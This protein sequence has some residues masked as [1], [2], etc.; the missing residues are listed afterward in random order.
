MAKRKKKQGGPTKKQI[1]L[2]KK[3]QRFRRRLMIGIGAV[4]A[5]IV[6][7][8]IF[9]FYRIYIAEPVSPVAVVNGTS[10]R[11]DYY[12]KMVRYQRYI[13]RSEIAQLRNRQA[14]LNPEDENTS[15]LSDYL[16][17]SIQQAESRL[18]TVGIDVLDELINDELIRQEATKRGI[19]LS[20]QEINEGIEK[21]FGFI[22]NQ[23]TPT[24]V[25]ATLTITPTP[26]IAPMTEEQ[27]KGYYQSYLDTIAKVA[28][29]SEED[30]RH[31]VEN[32][33]L[34]RKLKEALAEEVPTAAEQVH[35]RHILV[36]TEEKAKEVLKRLEGGE[37]FAALA[38]ELSTDP[39]T[40]D[41]GGDLG[42]FPRGEMV[43]A[44][45][46]VAFSLQ[47]GEVVTEPVRTAYG[48][49]IIKVE[50]KD[51]NR[52]LSELA[53]LR[54]KEQ[55]L[56]DWLEEQKNL[57]KIETHWSPDKVPP[58]EFESIPEQP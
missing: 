57:A 36:E 55:A 46:E 12:Q 43:P 58:E 14:Q 29:F 17:Q 54:K 35:V 24:P 48:F 25:T 34:A 53:L 45:E 16:A 33:L 1:A 10:I 32:S 56:N 38:E 31:I 37:D 8:L 22:R 4:V 39:S 26:T 5:A 19:T 7:V 3:E 41:K 30:F 20:S 51:E 15:L 47:P 2:S 18:T 49:H 9:G 6:L 42:W 13:I 21:Q 27:F 40:K 50:E 44:F 28:G 52:P 23:P 11:T